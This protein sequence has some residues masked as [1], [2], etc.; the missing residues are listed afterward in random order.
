MGLEKRVL[1]FGKDDCPYTSAAREAYAQQGYDVDYRNAK[2]SH[3][4]LEEMLR[5]SKGVRRVPVI[6]DEGKVTV[7]YGGT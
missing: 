1:I 5:F 7:G 3:T 4:S 2:T 6:V